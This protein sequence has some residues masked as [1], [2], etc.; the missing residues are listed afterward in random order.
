MTNDGGLPKKYLDTT[1][2]WIQD[3]EYPLNYQIQLYR[4]NR[5]DTNEILLATF[6]IIDQSYDKQFKPEV[7]PKIVQDIT[8]IN[9]NL[10][11]DY[12]DTTNT[13]ITILD[14]SL[15][16]DIQVS[17]GFL[18]Y[19]QLDDT[20]ISRTLPFVENDVDSVLTF[21]EGTTFTRNSANKIDLLEIDTFNE[22]IIIN[23]SASYGS[24]SIQLN[25][26]NNTHNVKIIAPAHSTFSGGNYSLTLPADLGTT[27]QVLQITPNARNGVLSFRDRINIFD[28]NESQFENVSG[29]ISII[30]SVLGS[31]GGGGGISITDFNNTQFENN[32]EGKITIKEDVLGSGGGVV[33]YDEIN[34]PYESQQTTST[35]TVNVVASVV[36]EYEILTFTHSGGSELQTSHT[37]TFTEETKCDILVVG[38]GGSGGGSLGGGGGGGGVLFATFDSI[39]AGSYNIKVGKGGNRVQSDSAVNS[40]LGARLGITG[41][42][43]E[44]EGTIVYGGG[45]GG[46][47]RYHA[48]LSGGSGGGGGFQTASGGIKTLPTYGSFITT[49]NSTYYGNDG[50]SVSNASKSGDGGS[51]NFTSDISGTNYIYS[52]GGTGRINGNDNSITNDDGV[53]YG[54]GGGGGGWSSTTYSGK[55]ADGIVI[56]RKYK[57]PQ[58]IYEDTT[59]QL[60]NLAEQKT[61][62]KGWR[63]VRFLPPTSSAWYNVNDNSLGTAPAYGTAYDYTNEWSVDYGGT[64]NEMFFSTKNMVYW[65]WTPKSSVDAFYSNAGRLVYKSSNNSSQHNVDWYNRAGTDPDPFISVLNHST[66]VNQ[67]LYAENSF[68]SAHTQLIP[69]NEGMCVFVRTSTDIETINPAPEYKTLT[70]THQLQCYPPASHL[71]DDTTDPTGEITTYTHNVPVGASYGAGDYI[72]TTSS[73]DSYNWLCADKLFSDKTDTDLNRVSFEYNQYHN[74][75]DYETAAYSLGGYDGDWI[76]VQFPESKV[77]QKMRIYIQ[78]DLQ[79]RAPGVFKIFGSNDGSSW[80]EIYHQSTQLTTANYIALSGSGINYPFS[81]LHESNIKYYEFNIYN[82][83]NY[84]HYA[85]VVNKITGDSLRLDFVYLEFLM[86]Q[87]YTLTFDNPTECDILIVGGGGAGGVD[88]GGGGGGGGV[89]YATNIELNGEYIIKVGNGGNSSTPVNS[90]DGYNATN[91]GN[92]YSSI[93]G[94]TGDLL[95]VLGGG[96]GGNSGSSGASAT[97]GGSGG[98][99]GGGVYTGGSG[100]SKTLPTYNTFITSTNSTYYAGDGGS[101]VLSGSY[102]GGGGGGAGG[103]TPTNYNG[104]DGIQINIDGNNY[105]YGGGGGG[106]YWTNVAGSGGLGGGGGGGGSSGNGGSGGIGGRTNGGDGTGGGATTTPTGIGG[107]GGSGTGGGGGGDAY[108]SPNKGGNGGSGIVIIRYKTTYTQTITI[109]ADIKPKGIMTHTDAGWQLI[110]MTDFSIIQALVSEIT[111][112][113]QRLNALEATPTP[114]N[115][116]VWSYR[117]F[118]TTTDITINDGTIIQLDNTR[119]KHKVS[120][121]ITYISDFVPETKT[122]QATLEISGAQYG[123]FDILSVPTIINEVNESALP[124]GAPVNYVYQIVEDSIVIGSKTIELYRPPGDVELKLTYRITT[125]SSNQTYTTDSDPVVNIP[126]G[127]WYEL[128]IDDINLYIVG[129]NEYNIYVDIEEADGSTSGDIL[130][131]QAITSF[132]V[133]QY[134]LSGVWN[135]NRIYRIKI[136]PSGAQSYIT[137]LLTATI[138][139]SDRFSGGVGGGTS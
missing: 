115:T 86:L 87:E 79:T 126:T 18:N 95:E 40:G 137:P 88:N 98:S 52:T 24:G 25:C 92:G 11:I 76:K 12:S 46:D 61:G 47:Y 68:S 97:N 19:T 67:C 101:G 31:G 1:T 43:T 14:N 48:G 90:P 93:F 103:T 8:K 132:P 9:N 133:A 135:S 129:V 42:E 120:I 34:V 119:V 99:G 105:Y 56:I 41:T 96:Y 35:E 106:I 107:N 54:D 49:D 78:S 70:F 3:T 127:T 27:G 57:T 110:D 7:L 109:G 64:F 2:N 33:D 17:G 4:S 77:L 125:S 111:L 102:I 73:S 74:P 116:I 117:Y 84:L 85:M 51:A 91:S 123:G 15:V 89:L 139:G 122:Y 69:G 65:L 44:F 10:Q 22:N 53:N 60:Q 26:E 81:S 108:S 112:L 130:W 5:D 28:F 136:R 71:K 32:A 21:F 100:G 118:D 128:F 83:T 138:Y 50:E 121:K 113:K 59:H 58:P 72:I 134:L 39:P 104:A 23:G 38:G 62:V 36:P 55:G 20:V 131:T 37:L 63:L 94:K 45:G 16:K 66:A 124:T 114:T 29:K 30:P 6:K 75:G 13:T 80:N 82:D